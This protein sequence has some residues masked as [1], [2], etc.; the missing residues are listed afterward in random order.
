MLNPP[1]EQGRIGLVTITPGISVTL[2]CALMRG[3][4]QAAE[5]VG[6]RDVVLAPGSRILAVPPAPG[7]RPEMHLID[8]LPSRHRGMLDWKCSCIESSDASFA[9]LER[10]FSDAIA[11][12]PAGDRWSVSPDKKL[13]TA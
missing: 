9:S 3:L 7:D 10:A 2:L 1:D 11:H 4:G 8:L 6:C 5:A 12:V 13:V